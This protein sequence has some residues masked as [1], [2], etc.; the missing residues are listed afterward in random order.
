MVGPQRI[1]LAAREP[2]CRFRLLLSPVRR[3][4][5]GTPW[6]RAFLSTFHAKRG[7]AWNFSRLGWWYGKPR[8]DSWAHHFQ[9]DLCLPASDFLDRNWRQP[10]GGRTS[11]ALFRPAREFHQRGI[12]RQNQPRAVGD[13]VSC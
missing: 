12:V 6:I 8:R 11:W 10:G 3:F 7:S 13:P 4:D 5:R 1:R 9:L 2:G